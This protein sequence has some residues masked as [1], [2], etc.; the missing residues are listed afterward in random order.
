MIFE[1]LDAKYLKRQID[2]LSNINISL[3]QL[4]DDLR[5]T[6]NR[7][8]T[9][10]Y[11]RLAEIVS[12]LN[13]NLDTRA[14]E[15]TLSKLT[16]ALSSVGTDKF[17]TSL[18]DALPAGDNWIGRVKIGDGSNIV[19]LTSATVGGSTVNALAVVPDLVKMFAGGTNYVYNELTVST[20][21]E[22]STYSPPLKFAIL[23]NRDDT[24]NILVRFNDPDPTSPTATQIEIP[25]GTA[26]VCMYP[27]S[28]LNYVASGGSPILVVVGFQ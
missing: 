12:R 16:N 8:L 23:S 15:S 17:R 9:D 22:Y 1:Y 28:T 20:T 26:K 3:T 13:V 21:E 10:L 19:S 14:S 18:V 2:K 6:D 25:A 4:R 7:T 27:I 11:N 5:G 24:Y